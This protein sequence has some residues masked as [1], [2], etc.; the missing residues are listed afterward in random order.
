MRLWLAAWDVQCEIYFFIVQRK[1]VNPHDAAHP[2]A[3]APAA[4]A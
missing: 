2:S 3:H 4:A 1:V